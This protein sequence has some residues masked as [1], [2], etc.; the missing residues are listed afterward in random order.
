MI[1]TRIVLFLVRWVGGRVDVVEECGVVV[2]VGDIFNHKGANAALML[3]QLFLGLN[4][5]KN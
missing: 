3:Q 1:L 5:R 2:G 4:Q